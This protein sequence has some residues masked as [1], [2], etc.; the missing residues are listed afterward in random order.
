M[1]AAQ[2]GQQPLPGSPVNGKQGQVR[3]PLTAAQ[4]KARLKKAAITRAANKEA[5]GGGPAPPLST[6]RIIPT[7][8]RS[9]AMA[10]RATPSQNI[11]AI[12][13]GFAAELLTAGPGWTEGYQK[14]FLA[15]L[16]AVLPGICT[17]KEG[18]LPKAA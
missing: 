18:R 1:S 3:K 7:A 10:L 15:G 5:M 11:N 12:A 2:T 4:L 8:E 17:P 6:G 13:Q 9:A 16:T 14:Q